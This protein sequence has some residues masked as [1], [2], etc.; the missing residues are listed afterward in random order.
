[1]HESAM[2]FIND[3]EKFQKIIDEYNKTFQYLLKRESSARNSNKK[4]LLTKLQQVEL[5]DQQQ[6]LSLQQQINE[7][8]D[9]VRTVIR[10]IDEQEEQISD[11]KFWQFKYE[12]GNESQ[13]NASSIPHSKEDIS[14]QLSNT[15]KS[16][17]KI[18]KSKMP[19]ALSAVCSFFNTPYP[20]NTYKRVVE[21][22]QKLEIMLN[23]AQR[24]VYDAVALIE[25]EIN[26]A[27]ARKV[28]RLQ[29]ENQMFDAEATSK[30]NSDLKELQKLLLNGLEDTFNKNTT[31]KLAYD[32]ITKYASVYRTDG[33]EN[34]SKIDFLMLGIGI[35]TISK[36]DDGTLDKYLSF[37]LQDSIYSNRNLFLPVA[38]NRYLKKPVC[39]RY[40]LKHS[41]TLYSLFSNYVLQSMNIF[42]DI[43]T[44][45]YIVD[46][47]NVG[48]KYSKFSIFEDGQKSKKVNIVRTVSEL[49]L[50]TDELFEYIL[51]TN[52]FYLRDN[53]EDI[54]SYNKNNVPKR[55]LKML[56][57]SN[58]SEI[59]SIELFEKLNLI[60]KNGNRNGVVTFI[61]I[62]DEE[63]ELNQVTIR[64]RNKA[65]NA[66]F[67]ISNKIYINSDGSMSLKDNSITLLAPP[68]IKQSIG[69]YIVEE[70]TQNNVNQTIV[71]LI[72][73]MPDDQD[74][75]KESCVSNVVIPIG[76]DPHGKQYSITLDKNNS[77]VLIAGNP[78]SGK[79]SLLHTMILQCITR[80]SPQ[81]LELYLVD[82][83]NGSEF[84]IYSQK[85]LKSIKV[86]LDDSE[87][88]IAVN[89][90]KYISSIVQIRNQKFQK[91]AEVS[92]KIVKNIEQ[93]Y[94]VNAEI[95]AMEN[96]PRTLLI[97]D[98]FQ[99]LYNSSR[100][101]GEITNYLVRMCRTVGIHIIM[102]SQ[103]VRRDYTS[104]SFD[105]QTKE[106][107]TYRVMFKLPQ[108]GAKEIMPE[109]NTAI[110]NAQTLRNGQMIINSNMGDDESLNQVVQCFYPDE[111]TI[112]TVCEKIIAIQGKQNGII[113][114]SEL[115]V[116]ASAIY[117]AT[118]KIIIGES[119]RLYYDVYNENSD[120]FIDNQIIALRNQ[121]KHLIV[122]GNDFRVHASTTASVVAHVAN[123]Y[124]D[125][126]ICILSSM[127]DY[128]KLGF[129]SV[130]DDYIHITGSV[131]DFVDYCN[132]QISKQS[133]LLAVIINPYSY[134]SIC[135]NGYLP[136]MPSAVSQ[137]MNV[138]RSSSVFSLILCEDFSKLKN[139]CTY[140]DQ[141]ISCRL[142]SVGSLTSMRSAM[143]NV[144]DRVK[145]SAFNTIRP[146]VVK[147]YYYNKSSD[148]LGRVR[149]P[150]AEQIFNTINIDLND[151][152]KKQMKEHGYS[153]LSGKIA[154]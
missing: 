22:R 147:A 32:V 128:N 14:L 77:S 62:P 86:T 40:S 112:M 122:C 33:V 8:L 46:C 138:V 115:P 136:N 37:I 89:F 58:I 143:Q 98:E 141:E 101:T 105:S 68:K 74:F 41:D 55:E 124:D 131:E 135:M 10:F 28:I 95:H 13:L 3:F 88:D 6:K 150:L 2:E 139:S 81:N 53:F 65:I 120:D 130:F 25:A 7:Q 84:N 38:L 36:V 15:V 35:Q 30:K 23:A 60:V 121:V 85:G 39:I 78:S 114:N 104:N 108:S 43:G 83:K 96:I 51:E 69:S 99:S 52:K 97:I 67:D 111:E 94:K 92:G 9:N 18:T 140:F 132:E 93:F 17:E 16:I 103:R 48:S 56:F 19:K 134:D 116:D 57:I 73:Y 29:N 44:N 66:L 63:F 80:Y 113:L 129:T 123:K 75:F 148:K 64:E 72:N 91:L 90:L 1:M 144:N 117:Q 49:K 71:P 24:E 11:S 27:T 61:G 109:Q 59:S 47:S 110:N 118:D 50:V 133:F 146:S 153:G 82:L 107:F 102:A 119:N 5:E 26:K 137:M 31:Y 152:E 142:I 4:K 70:N 76:F 21:N 54:E 12:N 34:L 126:K 79:S 42:S 100:S 45:V 87:P 154:E 145:E 151:I 20:K 127:S 125:F 106:Y 149:L